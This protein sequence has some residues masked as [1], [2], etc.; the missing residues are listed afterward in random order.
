LSQRT[1]PLRAG[2]FLEYTRLDAIEV[3]AGIER[4]AEVLGGTAWR[5]RS[6]RSSA[7]PS[8]G[9]QENEGRVAHV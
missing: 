9:L 8:D 7:L 5:T 2:L 1:P 3:R 6:L 4:L